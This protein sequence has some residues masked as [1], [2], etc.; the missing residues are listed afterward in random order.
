M[1]ARHRPSP[2]SVSIKGWKKPWTSKWIIGGGTRHF[3]FI[4]FASGYIDLVHMVQMS[5]SK[6]I[7]SADTAQ[8]RILS[9]LSG[10]AISILPC[11][12][13]TGT[14]TICTRL[15]TIRPTGSGWNLKF[16]RSSKS[17]IWASSIL[18]GVD[19]Y[20]IARCWIDL[21]ESP[22]VGENRGEIYQLSNNVK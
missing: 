2:K 10:I 14:I 15:R 17:V 9:I 13:M 5:R 8:S 4:G 1:Y 12:S 21:H 20:L 7:T 11:C 18:L 6:N 22:T 3:Q 16:L 19:Q